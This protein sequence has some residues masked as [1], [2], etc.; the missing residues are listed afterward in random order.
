MAIKN[1]RGFQEC[2]SNDNGKIWC[3]WKTIGPVSII[4]NDYQQITIKLEDTLYNS[5]TFISAIY[6]KCTLV[7]RQDLWNSLESTSMGIND[8]WCIG[9]D[10]N[11]IYDPGAKIGGKPHKMYKSIDFLNCMDN[12]GVTDIG[13]SGPKFT[14]C[15]NRRP[16]QR[17]WKRLDRVFINDKWANFFQNTTINHLARTG[18]DHRPL[19]MKCFNTNQNFIKYFR[20]L[21]IWTKQDGFLNIVKE[22][23]DT[24]ITGNNMWRLQSKLKLLSRKLSQR[25]RNTVGCS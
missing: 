22:T 8:P 9:G 3:L 24:Q 16:S 23:W 2:I 4:T 21:N 15:N 5:F 17:I 11:V 18:S 10:F 6:S 13:F 25:S 7:E 20:F 14:W 12:C 19:L 1:S